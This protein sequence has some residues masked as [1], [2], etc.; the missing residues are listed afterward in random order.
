MIRLGLRLFV[1][2]I[3][4]VVLSSFLIF[5][6][7][8]RSIYA[9]LEAEPPQHIAYQMRLT[10]EDIESIPPSEQADRIDEMSR[11][12]G[13]PIH[14]IDADSPKIP[15]DVKT[16]IA[17][18]RSVIRFVSN[19]QWFDRDAVAYV[20]MTGGSKVLMMG[21][22]VEKVGPDS[23]AFVRGTPLFLV[24][25]ALVATILSIPTVRRARALAKAAVRIADG[26]LSARAEVSG[27][28]EL[29][30]LGR[31][32]NRMADRVQDLLETQ[33]GILRAVSHELRTPTS[34][35]RFGLDL[36]ETAQSDEE[37]ARRIAAIDEDLT[38]LDYLVKELLQFHRV[39]GE[40]PQAERMDINVVELLSK[41]VSRVSEL[42]PDIELVITTLD[43]S[44]NACVQPRFFER[45]IG[46]LLNNALRY[47]T[48]RIELRVERREDAVF[49]TVTDDGPGIPEADRKRIFEPFYRTD[50]SRSKESGGIGMG[51]AIVRTILEGHQGL[52]TV[53]SAPGGGAKFETRWPAV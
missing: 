51:L 48:T 26:D 18:G 3:F 39:E 53:S 34:R 23:W 41:M 15:D 19:S 8:S 33:R 30:N 16:I 42:R 4:V 1:G 49:V 20:P 9:Q 2:L 43:E 25:V 22:M 50:D 5:H 29:E 7:A 10:R 38:E 52:V 46:N 11:G 13:W 6:V 45:A 12:M 31:Q 47:A 24:L 27:R 28:D 35:I 32:F 40:I 14:L 44:I 36:L 17:D 37:R 21:P